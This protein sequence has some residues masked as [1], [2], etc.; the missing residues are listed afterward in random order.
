VAAY[1]ALRDHL[2]RSAADRELYAATKRA[3]AR[4]PWA[5][6]NDYADA[7]SDVITGI[8]ARARTR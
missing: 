6:M 8:L 5:D 7:K 1:L 3:L 4:R 2:R